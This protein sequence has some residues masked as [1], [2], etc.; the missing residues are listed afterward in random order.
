MSWLEIKQ[1]HGESNSI[2]IWGTKNIEPSLTIPALQSAQT[3]CRGPC[4]EQA[5]QRKRS[6]LQWTIMSTKPTLA[7]SECISQLCER[8]V[9][10]WSGCHWNDVYITY[11]IFSRKA[12]CK[13]FLDLIHYLL[14]IILLNSPFF[15]CF[16][17]NTKIE[18]G[19]CFIDPTTSIPKFTNYLDVPKLKK[20]WIKKS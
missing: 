12:K 11:A 2:S 15:Q 17:I 6:S 8:E 20:Y 18:F 3:T 19:I 10:D 5:Q 9:P 7:C 4:S 1:A 16:S 13:N 14:L